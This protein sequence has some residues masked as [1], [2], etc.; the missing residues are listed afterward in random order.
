MTRIAGFVQ[1]RL[2]VTGLARFLELRGSGLDG[3]LAGRIRADVIEGK[4]QQTCD[5][6]RG[7]GRTHPFALDPADLS[8]ADADLTRDIVESPAPPL[9]FLPHHRF[10]T[11]SLTLR[12]T[13]TSLVA[14]FARYVLA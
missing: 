4:V 5:G 9:T 14:H 2:R 11:L 3:A 10:H 12:I 7:F 1:S 6:L 13:Y 8:A